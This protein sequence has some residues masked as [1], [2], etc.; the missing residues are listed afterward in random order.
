MDDIERD[1]NITPSRMPTSISSTNFLS[2]SAAGG[3]ANM[4][5]SPGVSP[6]STP[7]AISTPQFVDH[8]PLPDE[9]PMSRSRDLSV[10]RPVVRSTSPIGR[11]AE[12]M[13][14]PA[15]PSESAY[16]VS[17]RNG[18]ISNGSPQGK[19]SQAQTT[20][21]IGTLP[22]GEPI[23]SPSYNQSPSRNP[24]AGLGVGPVAMAG[25]G[26]GV[27]TTKA[28][29]RR[30]INPAMSFNIDPSNSTFAAEPRNS[31]LPPS[32]L[33]TSFTDLQNQAA[34]RSPSSPSP[35]PLGADGFPFKH[36]ADGLLSTPKASDPPPPPRTSSLPDQLSAH[37]APALDVTPSMPSRLPS[38]LSE[39]EDPNSQTPKIQAPTIRPM[40][41]SLSDPDFAL[42]LH[43]MDRE[44]AATSDDALKVESS[45]AARLNGESD[46]GDIAPASPDKIVSASSSSSALARSPHME[47]LASAVDAENAST[48]GMRLS[49][50]SAGGLGFAPQLLRTRQPSAES[51]T[52][53]S[54]RFAADSA[55]SHAADMLAAAKIGG[56]DSIEMDVGLLSGLI[57]EMDDMKETISALRSKYTG[58]KVSRLSRVSEGSLLTP[59]A[60]QSAI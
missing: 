49:P 17:S 14:L 16:P 39:Q 10:D 22:L 40:S 23:S 56:K 9:T 51:T 47:Q 8:P 31:P 38:G 48:L 4:V 2:S 46:N 41:F 3:L 52:S 6:T 32:P 21:S 33:R 1:T 7:V 37:D 13:P 42:I 57:G 27:P 28:E 18:P 15:S 34:P 44:A 60:D 43:Q 19:R 24:N 45:D 53:V 58:A 30:S 11:I 25:P 55:F 59:I 29:R 36:S 5:I 12:Q 50:S 20:P 26:L 54:S 35:M